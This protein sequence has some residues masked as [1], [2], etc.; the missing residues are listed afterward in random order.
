MI[1]GTSQA[2]CAILMI[3]SGQGEFEA[4]YAKTGSTRE[5]ALLAY[6]LG[7]KQ[8]IVCINKMDDKS[9]NW[10]EKRY[11]EIKDELTKF[12]GTCGYK[13]EKMNFVPISGWCGDNMIVIS[14]L[15]HNFRIVPPT[16]NGTRV[17]SS[18][19]P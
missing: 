2:D 8:M 5:H 18:L 11:N 17:L 12:L 10:D 16:L 14:S 15:F 19:R 6:T 3:A 7:V 1:T 4:G 13:T 9:V